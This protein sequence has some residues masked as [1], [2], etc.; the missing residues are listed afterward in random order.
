MGRQMGRLVIGRDTDNT[1]S[2]FDIWREVCRTE[3][4]YLQFK[5][6]INDKLRQKQYVR[7]N[8]KNYQISFDQ[9]LRYFKRSIKKIVFVSSLRLPVLT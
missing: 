7:A 6:K 4:K 8:Y 3:H 1:K 2:Y 5:V 9:K